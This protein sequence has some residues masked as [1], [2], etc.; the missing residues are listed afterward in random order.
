MLLFLL[1]SAFTVANGVVANQFPRIKH[2]TNTRA[3]H[4]YLDRLVPASKNAI[5][6][7]LMGPKVGSDVNSCPHAYHLMCSI[8]TSYFFFHLA[9]G[10]CSH[11]SRS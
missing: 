3:V 10:H 9:R 5:L 11:R 2:T 4:D 7:E 6:Y 1:L 8:L